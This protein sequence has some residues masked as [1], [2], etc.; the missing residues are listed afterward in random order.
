MPVL[1]PLAL[2]RAN[3]SDLGLV[4][5]NVFG[6]RVV[7]VNLY[8]VRSASG[9]WTLIDAGLPFS[10]TRIR[11][12]AN[13]HFHTPPAAIVLTHGHFDHV[14]ALR[15]LA[16][17]WNVPIY[18]HPLEF[19]YLTGRS[20]YPPPDPT[21][22]RGVMPMLSPLFPRGPIDVSDRLL[23]LPAEGWVPTLPG[24]RWIHTP[25]HT[26]GHVSLFRD[27][28]RVLI[29]GDAFINTRQE[30]FLAIMTQREEINGPPSYSPAIG[31]RRGNRWRDWPGSSLTSALRATV[32][33]DRL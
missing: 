21:L 17:G 2:M 24:W 12:W 18:A 3:D 22:G 8:G 13:E 27:E 1:D 15:D 5:E 26:A 10:A 31:M 19:P 14:G 23:P 9:G 33:A 20:S 28:D 16:D 30:S 32:A 29:A 4:T 25:G 11:A 7:M 6:L